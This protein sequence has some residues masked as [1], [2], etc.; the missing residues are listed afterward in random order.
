MARSKKRKQNQEEEDAGSTSVW[1][2]L[3]YEGDEE[4]G[5]EEEQV[6]D[7]VEIEVEPLSKKPINIGDLKRLV[8]TRKSKSLLHCN[9]DDLGVYPPKTCASR[10]RYSP[11]TPVT[12][13]I[14]G[15]KRTTPPHIRPSSLGCDGTLCP[16]VYA[17]Y[18]KN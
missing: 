12:E 6:G 4:E 14:N 2:Q 5:T 17:G 13:V 18:T 16:Y 9:A 11:D 10:A 7:P 8:Y 3:Y 15:L 1:V